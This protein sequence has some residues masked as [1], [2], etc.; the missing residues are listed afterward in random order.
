MQ[1]RIVYVA[2]WL[3]TAMMILTDWIWASRIG[4]RVTNS[5]AAQTM[6]IISITVA[7]SGL[8]WAVS[9]IHY[10][11]VS[12]NLFFRNVAHL[13]MWITILV[14]FTHVCVVFQ[15]LCVTT[16]FPLVS[17]VL[18]SADSALGFHWPDFYRWIKIH[19]WLDSALDLAYASGGYQLIAIPLILAVTL[20]SQDYAEFVAQFMVSTILVT[21]ISVPFPAESAFIHFGIHDPDTVSTV[22]DFALLRSRNIREL[23]FTSAQGLVSM[24]SLHAILALC[25]AYS[26]RHVR[27]VFPI[28]ITLNFLMVISTPTR[29]GHYL[30]DVLSGLVIGVLVIYFVRK[31]ILRSSS[32]VKKFPLSLST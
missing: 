7:I 13:F 27:F 17:N 2:L 29:G 25:F 4:L 16:D 23:A 18:I 19:H 3:L 15:Y 21:L 24:P 12:R 30:S 28:G 5:S 8:L 11:E 22:S 6:I 26:L 32:H 14:T 1:L 31:V 9:R 20:N 10:K